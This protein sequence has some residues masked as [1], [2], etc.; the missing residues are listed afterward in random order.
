MQ[1][2]QT[3][4]M[5][6]FNSDSPSPFE[7][8]IVSEA[9]FKEWTDRVKLARTLED[10]RK[11]GKEIEEETKEEFIN[12]VFSKDALQGEFYYI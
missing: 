11:I 2:L 6:Q 1:T 4:G 8:D 10:I 3:M 7:D 12:I 5:L 9:R